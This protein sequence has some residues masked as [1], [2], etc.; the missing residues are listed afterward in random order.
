MLPATVAF[1]YIAGSAPPPS[2]QRKTGLI[3]PLWDSL[4][5]FLFP[6]W[7]IER[8]LYVRAAIGFIAWLAIAH[9]LYAY[10][11]PSLLFVGTIM[12]LVM[13]HLTAGEY[14]QRWIVYK[15][16][17]SIAAANKRRIIDPRLRADYL[18]RHGT[19]N[20]AL[21]TN[22]SRREA[23]LR[24]ALR[25]RTELQRWWK[26]M[27]LVGAIIGLIRFVDVLLSSR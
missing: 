2:P 7:A 12:L 5:F 10:G 3:G 9:Q 4:A 20:P 25:P 24:T 22:P 17:R 21:W 13:L 23:R 11:E 14:G 18:R 8:R 16:Q 1:W 19:R 15:L 26:W 27:L 6:V